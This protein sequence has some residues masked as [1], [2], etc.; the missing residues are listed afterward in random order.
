VLGALSV[1]AVPAGVAASR[2]LDGVTLLRALY[3][4]VPAACLLGLLAVAFARRARFSAARSIRPEAVGAGRVARS[5]AFAGLYLGF[6]AALALAV[7]G[8]LRWAQ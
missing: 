8:A 3:V 1:L 6:T 4:M 2:Y 7:Y 5:L